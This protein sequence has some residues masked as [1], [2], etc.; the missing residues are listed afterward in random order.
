VQAAALHGPPCADT[1]C[2]GLKGRVP[3]GLKQGL[4][5]FAGSQT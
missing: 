3:G 1:L 2:S 4:F 5:A